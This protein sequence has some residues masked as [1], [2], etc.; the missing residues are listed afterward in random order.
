[1]VFSVA[2]TADGNFLVSGGEEGTMIIWNL[3]NI[4][5]LKPLNYACNWVQDCLQTN[6]AVEAG[7]RASTLRI[8][9]EP[10]GAFY[11]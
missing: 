2:F 5:T 1:M 6:A 10:R 3:K 11:Q 4:L 9:D 7:D 8:Y